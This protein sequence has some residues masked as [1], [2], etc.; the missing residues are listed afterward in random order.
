MTVQRALRQAQAGFSLI[1]LAL[2]MLVMGLLLGGVMMTLSMQDEIKRRTLTDQR[3]AEVREALI[4]FA[5]VNGRLPRPAISATDG[6]ER[7]LCANEPAPDCSGFV[8]WTALGVQ[9]ADGYDKLI[10]YSVTPSFANASFSM[11]TVPTKSVRSRDTLGA[12]TY[13]AGAAVCSATNG[14]TPA[15]IYSQGSSN[16]GTSVDGLP[17]PNPSATNVDESTNNDNTTV[18]F[19]SRY[20]DDNTLAIGGEF[21]DQAIWLP[22]SLLFGRMVQAGKLP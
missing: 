8:P 13:L 11:A 10:R 22:T 21:D 6:N 14:C 17:R 7:G 18:S 16:F 20:Y 9:R 15:V 5:L 4:G 12:L 19:I 1:E 2:V 3:L